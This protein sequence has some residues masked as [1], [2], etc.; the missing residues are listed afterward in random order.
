MPDC[1]SQG[2]YRQPQPAATERFQSPWQAHG[3]HWGSESCAYSTRN[4]QNQ[5]RGGSISG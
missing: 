2:P 1:I 5:Q 4:V 3:A